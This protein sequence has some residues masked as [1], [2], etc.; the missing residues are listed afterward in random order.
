MR[1]L[2]RLALLPLALPLLAGDCEEDTVAPEP[3][4]GTVLGTVTADGEGLPG[5][6]VTLSTGRT[7]TTDGGGRYELGDVPEGVHTVTISGFPSD[8]TFPQT[9]AVVGITTRDQSVVYD[10]AGSRVRT[11]SISGTVTVDGAP[12]EG[13]TVRLDGDAERTTNAQGSYSFTGLDS[14]QHMVSVVP[15]DDVE[16]DPSERIV[17]VAAGGHATADFSCVTPA[18]PGDPGGDQVPTAEELGE[19]DVEADGPKTSDTC[20]DG[21]VG[22]E[23]AEGPYEVVDEDRDGIPFLVL[24]LDA[25]VEGEY[26]P[27]TGDWTGVGNVLSQDGSIRLQE[28]VDGTWR[29]AD[30]G[31]IVFAGRLTAEFFDTNGTPQDFSDDAKICDA[32][33]D[34]SLTPVD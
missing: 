11:G 13:V 23:L 33:F 21:T 6:V 20:P 28:T 30:D 5:V 9:T 17:D 10:F 2:A 32:T 4:T 25:T 18:D 16:C 1:R 15:P 29:F 24:V 26:D 12:A 8:V 14:G 31:S 34:M 22:D 27:S 19:L 7:A 3:I